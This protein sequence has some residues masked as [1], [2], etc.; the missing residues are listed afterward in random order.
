VN[1]VGS[2]AFYSG[3]DVD[4]RGR[5]REELQIMRNKAD[6]L[7]LSLIGSLSFNS[8]S[9]YETHLELKLRSNI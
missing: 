8:G 2:G 6:G 3:G 9:E 1:T 7:E 4:M 5:R